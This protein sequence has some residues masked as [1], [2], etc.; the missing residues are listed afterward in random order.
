MDSILTGVVVAAEVAVF[1]PIFVRRIWRTFPVFCAYLFWALLS[2]VAALMMQMMHR[3]EAAYLS[4]YRV[5]MIIDSTLLFVVLVELFWSILRPVRAALP[6]GSV[7]VVAGLVA[8]VGLLIWPLAGKALPLHLAP[9]S[10]AIFRFQ[11]TFAILRVVCF[12][13]MAGFSQLL[14]IDWRDR[15]LQ[16]A[17]GLGIYALVSLTVTVFHAHQAGGTELYHHLDELVSFSY[18]GTLVYWV[19]SFAQKEYQRKEFSPQMQQFLVYMG[20]TARAGSIALSKLPPDNSRTR[21]K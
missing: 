11:Q 21:D 6:K 10:V 2:D 15:E 20:G 5:E 19:L 4:F 12:L 16:I 14:A 18:L 8:L 3:P 9:E 1:I 13:V 17:T 7:F